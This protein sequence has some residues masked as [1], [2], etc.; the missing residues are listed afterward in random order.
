MEILIL[1]DDKLILQ[2][3]FDEEL[4]GDLS[5]EVG[6]FDSVFWSLRLKPLHDV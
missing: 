4:A 3:V 6:V 5:F 1:G 2:H